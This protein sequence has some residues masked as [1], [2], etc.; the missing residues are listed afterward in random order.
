MALL[1]VRQLTKKYKELTAVNQVSF[2]VNAGEVV[3]LIG[4]N[5]AGKTTILNCLEGSIFTTEGDI[6][7][8]GRSLLKCGS[9]RNEFGFLIQANFFEYLN[10]YDN[11]DILLRLSGRRDK[12]ENNRR[13]MKLLQL[14][15][16]EAK[17]NSYVLTFS[18]GMKQRLGLAQALLNEPHF[19]VLDEP[20]VG[21]D[22]IG[23]NV[24]KAVIRDKA[25]KEGAGIL[26]SSHDLED[27]IEIC[28][29][30]IMLQKGKIIYDDVFH[31]LKQ[32]VIY[33]QQAKAAKGTGSIAG[34]CRK[35]DQV[36]CT[37]FE[38]FQREY[39]I[40]LMKG[41]NIVDIDIQVDSLYEFFEGGCRY[42]HID[43]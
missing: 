32:Y 40:A 30:V 43:Y 31:P 35:A 4:E 20:F 11:L 2:Q 10:A 13:I 29:R 16:L 8:Q 37:S 22:P 25:R 9:L 33:L 28:D 21:L 36:I 15:G 17:K 5:G 34:A 24:L 41:R 12:K 38:A 3:A 39:Q 27:V 1:E 19:L 6:C 7:Y 23:K 18:F 26:F 42:E 14:V